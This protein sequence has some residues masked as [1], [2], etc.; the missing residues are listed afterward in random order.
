MSKGDIQMQIKRA[1]EQIK[2]S[3]AILITSGAGMG[4]DSGLP[5][6]R[7]AEGFW[8][9]YPPIKKL[10]LTL[11][12]VSTPRWFNEDPEFAWGF[13]GHR[14]QLYRST[15]PHK[16][17]QILRKWIDSMRKDYFVFTSNVDGH[18]QK[19]G[20]PEDKIVECHGS[21][22]YLQ[23]VS[24]RGS[25]WPM[26]EGNAIEVDETT[27]K[28][29]KPLPMGP[30]DAKPEK[31][32]LARPNVLM[33]NDWYF[34]DDREQE[35]QHRYQTFVARLRAESCPFVVIEIGAG[36]AVPTIRWLGESIVR[37]S[38]HGMMIRINPVDTDIPSKHHVS[39]PI[40]GLEALK[41]IDGIIDK[42]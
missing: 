34:I 33:F 28:A 29:N 26:P 27:L 12:E 22:N 4:V 11:P 23:C 5:D 14:L 36:L 10:G 17:F 6:F 35:Q 18:F 39:L 15:K 38:A 19:A 32:E 31:Q 30:P 9:A 20:F 25:I 16:G 2:N 21:L 40:G 3:E 7:G 42:L 24:G 1:A 13:F 37:E 8:E 41:K